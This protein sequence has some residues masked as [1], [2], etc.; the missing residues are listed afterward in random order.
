MVRLTIRALR[1]G[2]LHIHCHVH[3][4]SNVLDEAMRIE[5]VMCGMTEQVCRRTSVRIRQKMWV[6]AATTR[7]ERDRLAERNPPPEG[8]RGRMAH[9]SGPWEHAGA[10][11]NTK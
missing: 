2:R 10:R 1:E 5:S 7:V 6:L 9:H 11:R 8:V 4:S 3:V